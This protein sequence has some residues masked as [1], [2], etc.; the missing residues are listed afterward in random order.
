[1]ILPKGRKELYAIWRACE[2]F[3]IRPP[4]VA[5]CWD[6][7]SIDTRSNLIGCSQIRDLEDIKN[8]EA[9]LR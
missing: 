4:G 2:R 3:N 7:C 8:M 1:M 6:D 5:A 9:G